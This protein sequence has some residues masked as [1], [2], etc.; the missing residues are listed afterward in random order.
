WTVACASENS[1]K[2]IRLPIDHVGVAVAAFGDQ[3][4]VFGYGCVG[5]AGP[6]AVDHFMEVV[7]RRN[8]SCF[9]L[10]LVDAPRDGS[11]E[12]DAASVKSI[13]RGP[14]LGGRIRQGMLV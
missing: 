10:L 11:R 4:D 8:V 5:W 13:P 14:A 9:H 1:R 3:S 12:R 6:L 2:H 7:R